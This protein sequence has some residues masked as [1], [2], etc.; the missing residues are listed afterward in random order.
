MTNKNV[1]KIL[2]DNE[3]PKNYENYINELKM[4]NRVAILI[5]RNRTK[6]GAI[7]FDMQENKVILDSN[8]KP[9]D[10]VLRERGTGEKLIEDSWF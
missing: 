5:R 3:I 2:E 9:L 4:L 7:D 8:G 1:N 10:I 6:G